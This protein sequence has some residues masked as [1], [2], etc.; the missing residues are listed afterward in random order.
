MLQ[1]IVIDA[2]V[3]LGPDLT[4]NQAVTPGQDDT[5]GQEDSPPS[6]DTPDQ[7]EVPAQEVG[8]PLAGHVQD[9]ADNIQILSPL[10][11]SRHKQVSDHL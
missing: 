7:D 10:R 3:G 8:V 6:Q 11:Y 9:T 4:P 5:T 2:V 1:D